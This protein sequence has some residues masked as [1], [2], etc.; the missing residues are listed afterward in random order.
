MPKVKTQKSKTKKTLKSAVEKNI[1]S[2][3]E[4]NQA[5][6]Q[7]HEDH[8]QAGKTKKNYNG[9]L[10]RGDKILAG[11]VQAR[12]A[13]EK[14][15]KVFSD[16]IISSKLAKAFDNPPNK[17]S[18]KALELIL[19][20]KCIHEGCGKSTMD[21]MHAAYA[22]RWDEMY[23]FKPEVQ[24]SYWLTDRAGRDGEKYAGETYCCDKKTGIVTGNPARS[25][26]INTFRQV[27]KSRAAAKGVEAMMVEDIE[28]MIT[29]LENKCPK[30]AVNLV[31]SGSDQN[32][33][34]VMLVIKHTFL[35]GFLS[36]GFTLWTR[37]NELCKLQYGN[38]T[39]NCPG[40]VL[41]FIEHFRVHLENRKGWQKKAVMMHIR[42]TIDMISTLNQTI[43]PKREIQSHNM[44]QSLIQD[45]AVAAGLTK[46][47]TTHSLRRG[48][49]QYHFMWAEGKQR[50]SLTI[51]HWW[52]GWAED[53]RVDTLMKYLM[54]S[55]QS[56]ETGHG[57]ALCPLRLEPA[58]SFMSNH[59]LDQPI[60]VNDFR[61]FTAA[62]MGANQRVIDML[63]VTPELSLVHMRQMSLAG[64]E[65]QGNALQPSQVSSTDKSMESI[66]VQKCC[67]QK[68]TKER[69]APIPGI[70]VPDIPK[71]GED[72]FLAVVKQ[73][74]E[75]DPSQGLATPL[76]DWPV[77]WHTGTM[78]LVTG[79][80]CSN[81]KLVA[82][83]Y[84]RL[85][86][87]KDAFKAAYPGI[88]NNLT[89]LYAAIQ[90]RNP[91]HARKSKN[92]SREERERQKTNNGGSHEGGSGSEDGGE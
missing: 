23:V 16:G 38:L 45:A 17:W 2:I 1:P 84:E 11:I 53:E 74:E 46:I 80:K 85:G 71:H 91:G 22:K 43:Q 90:A 88:H 47:F 50:W 35:R 9:Y 12:K 61:H 25:H 55:L 37:N 66:P 92:G 60:T 87:S 34:H 31:L 63:R 76:K 28:A 81:R 70:I 89:K 58:K 3:D 52:G 24:M 59:S 21:G 8:G 73:W 5:G 79:T 4:L 42:W 67:R 69:N 44:I 83:E 68:S 19:I 26:L 78:R 86:R 20:Q 41:D 54:D 75:G 39:W 32:A 82:E 14:E 30:S 40:L 29:W 72:L 7:T 13:A 77:E 18:S 33:E 48:G 36:S 51:V 62:M 15:G 49:A 10:E 64:T 65:A 57:N 56:Y 27:I 6:A